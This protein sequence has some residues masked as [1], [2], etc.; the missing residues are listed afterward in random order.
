MKKITSFILVVLIGILLCACAKGESG[1]KVSMSKLKKDIA[2]D[3]QVQACFT[4]DYVNESK[5]SVKSIEIVKER[6]NENNIITY[7]DVVLENTYFTISLY[8]KTIYNYYDQGGWVMDELCIEE[9]KDIIPIRGPE[10]KCVE[11]RIEIGEVLYQDDRKSLSGA[12]DLSVTDSVLIN[13]NTAHVS[14]QLQTDAVGFE[15]Y[16]VYTWTE[17]GW[18]PEEKYQDFYVKNYTTDYT[19]RLGHFTVDNDKY[20][21]I[22]AE[23]YIIFDSFDIEILSIEGT[24][25][26]YILNSCNMRLDYSAVTGQKMQAE[27]DP[28]YGRFSVGTHASFPNTAPIFVKYS[29]FE[30]GW[31]V[32]GCSL[33][34]IS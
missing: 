13:A 5:Y 20:Y 25:V 16:F 8:I 11:E 33:K 17:N 2:N 3:S 27:F 6:E 10:P 26:T 1:K 15:G 21:A 28:F 12:Y 32:E 19:S 34:K 31:T 24:T 29:E 4:S 14:A 22:G 18:V 23:K 7:S 30:N 9:T